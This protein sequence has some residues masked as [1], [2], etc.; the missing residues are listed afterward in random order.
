MPADLSHEERSGWED[1][2]KLFFTL[3]TD[4][5]EE[6]KNDS[7]YK[8]ILQ[9]A[10]S[11]GTTRWGSK[12]VEGYVLSEK[13]ALQLFDELVIGFHR[14]ETLIEKV[15]PEGVVRKDSNGKYFRGGWKRLHVK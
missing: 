5:N 8:A 2:V 14:S 3:I 15:L 6:T 10:M 12:E 1:S 13:K 9:M 7:Y 11:F 4:T